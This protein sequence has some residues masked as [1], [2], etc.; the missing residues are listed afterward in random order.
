MM[1]VERVS[2][3]CVVTTHSLSDCVISNFS[4]VL[5]LRHARRMNSKRKNRPCREPRSFSG[6]SIQ[7]HSAS[8]LRPSTATSGHAPPPNHF[9]KHSLD[10]WLL[11]PSTTLIRGEWTSA[12]ADRTGAKRAELP[13]LGAIIRRSRAPS[14]TTPYTQHL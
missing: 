13:L 9:R 4:R 8:V 14:S 3:A 10:S 6:D 12:G 5:L 1:S 11:T 7:R 2:V